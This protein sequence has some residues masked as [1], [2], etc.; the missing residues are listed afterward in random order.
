MSA[1][2][3]QCSRMQIFPRRYPAFLP[4]NPPSSPSHETLCSTRICDAP[5]L[6]PVSGGELSPYSRGLGIPYGYVSF[7]RDA[8]RHAQIVFSLLSPTHLALSC[9]EHAR[10]LRAEH[11]SQDLAADLTNGLTLPRNYHFTPIPQSH[12]SC[13]RLCIPASGT[14][15]AHRV[16]LYLLHSARFIPGFTVFSKKPKFLQSKAFSYRCLLVETP[17]YTYGCMFLAVSLL[18]VYLFRLFFWFGIA[19]RSISVPPRTPSQ[20]FLVLTSSPACIVQL[21][22]H[23]LNL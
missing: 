20:F 2:V 13:S 7:S 5:L 17:V 19:S 10:G 1:G 12:G 16:S 6:R 9:Q 4:Q 18:P 11:R 3:A 15:G 23:V 14:D 22:E 21:S 8:A